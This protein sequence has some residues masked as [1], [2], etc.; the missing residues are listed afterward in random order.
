MKDEAQYVK[1]LPVFDLSEHPSSVF[2]VFCLMT[3]LRSVSVF[4]IP[5]TVWR[6]LS[7]A[8]L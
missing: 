6:T 2:V 8:L 4:V 3:L 1:V 7:E 5:L